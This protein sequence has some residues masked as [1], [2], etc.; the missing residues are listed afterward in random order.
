[1]TFKFTEEIKRMCE[2]GVDKKTIC[3]KSGISRGAL[4]RYIRE[5][6]CTYGGK[7][8]K[9]DKYSEEDKD[10]IIAEVIDA[11]KNDKTVNSVCKK[12]ELHRQTLK[13][14]LVDRNI[15]LNQFKSNG[16]DEETLKKLEL[17][18]KKNYSIAKISNLLNL[19]KYKV[20]Q[21]MDM[22]SLSTNGNNYEAKLIDD[23]ETYEDVKQCLEE[24]MSQTEL[25]KRYGVSTSRMHKY[26]A[27]KNISHKTRATATPEALATLQSMV[28][29][30][31]RVWQMA[32]VLDVCESTVSN[33]IQK[34][35]IRKGD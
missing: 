6:Y 26:I 32:K 34:Y 18:C 24:G 29:E 9:R 7:T 31:A 16:L 5:G 19:T 21:Y 25:A 10:S 2:E 20:R 8:L 11:V 12:Y 30:G 27:K 1:M 33:W 17:Y 3:E 22:Y 28:N 35:D 4:N 13:N 14:W 15:D 23:S